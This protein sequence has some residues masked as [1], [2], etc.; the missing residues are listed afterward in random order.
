MLYC[1]ECEKMVQPEYSGVF[2]HM[3][4][5]WNGFSGDVEYC[6]FDMG[7][8]SCPP[9]ELPEDWIEYV[10][11]IDPQELEAINAEAKLILADL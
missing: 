4:A 1:I 11:D 5:I 9:P 10:D 7:W 3:N 6:E 2:G 8:A